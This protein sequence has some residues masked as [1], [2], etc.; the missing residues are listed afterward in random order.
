[1]VFI[2]EFIK[3]KVAWGFMY[4]IAVVAIGILF[5]PLELL[6]YVFTAIEGN[7]ARKNYWQTSKRRIWDYLYYWAI[8]KDIP[9]LF[10]DITMKLFQQ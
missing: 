5:L 4:K 7:D 10:K 1:M 2:S 9:K 6:G 8:G 3:G